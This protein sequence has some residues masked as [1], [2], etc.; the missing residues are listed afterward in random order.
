[1]T[2]EEYKE[3]IKALRCFHGNFIDFYNNLFIFSG[4]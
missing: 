4:Y 3:I 2:Q 1:M